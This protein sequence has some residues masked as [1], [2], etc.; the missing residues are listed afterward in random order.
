MIYLAADHR[1]FKLKEEL[2]KFI[3]ES[4]FEVKDAGAFKYNKDDDYVDFAKDASERLSGANADD[5]GIFICGS[6]HGMAIVADK[7]K[8]LR[9]AV[10]FNKD[11]AGQSRAHDNANVLALAADWLSSDEAK[12]I[13]LVWLKTPF[14]GEERHVR[15]IGKIKEIE[16]KNFFAE[17]ARLSD[18]HGFTY[19]GK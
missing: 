19:G 3:I 17:G 14:L 6:G 7:F 4:G 10:V 16:E 15:R 1:G 11:V 8:G 13:V 9:A 18:G 2:K 5:R 12:E